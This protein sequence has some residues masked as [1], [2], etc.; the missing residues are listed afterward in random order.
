MEYA[1]PLRAVAETLEKGGGGGTWWDGGDDYA[2]FEVL[3]NRLI[4][5]Y[6]WVS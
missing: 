6:F 1:V 2:S 5:S 3:R 4:A